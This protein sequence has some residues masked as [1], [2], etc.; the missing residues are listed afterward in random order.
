VFDA[1]HSVVRSLGPASMECYRDRVP[2]AHIHTL[3][4]QSPADLDGELRGWLAEAYAVG[5]GNTEAG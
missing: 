2:N 4:L 1:L 5:V 3:R